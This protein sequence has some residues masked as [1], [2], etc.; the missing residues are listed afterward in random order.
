MSNAAT[1]AK[2][3][4]NAKSHVQVKVHADPCVA[5][6]FKSTCQM[7]G[8]SMASVLTEFMAQYSGIPKS[9]ASATLD[10]VSTRRKRRKI[11]SSMA[12][13][14]EKVRDAEENYLFNIPEN[15]QGASIYDAAEQSVS[16]MDEVIEL[17]GE[18]Y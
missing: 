14:L 11:V 6:A 12:N 4:W 13:R 10:D 5:A 9:A 1:R 18:I 2:A 7:V 17:L 15:L 16:I 8:R 3:K